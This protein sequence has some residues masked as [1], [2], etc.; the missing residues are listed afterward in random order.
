M[1]RLES[2]ERD[3][4]EVQDSRD[5]YDLN[6]TC[7]TKIEKTRYVLVVGTKR[8]SCTGQPNSVPTADDLI[9]ISQTAES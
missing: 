5:C 1:L 2:D 9:T 8:I 4:S 3:K 7:Y 6:E